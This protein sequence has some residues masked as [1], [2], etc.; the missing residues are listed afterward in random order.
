MSLTEG[1]QNAQS[2]YYSM[3]TLHRKGTIMDTKMEYEAPTLIEV[4]SFEDITKGASSGASLD[5]DFADN[6]PADQ[7][8][9]S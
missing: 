3:G 1:L 4:G 7:L 6:F 9:F 8:T 2:P 5:A